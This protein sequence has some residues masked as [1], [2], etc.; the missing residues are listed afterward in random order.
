MLA[1]VANMRPLFHPALFGTDASNEQ[2]RGQPTLCSSHVERIYDAPTD[3]FP[4]TV[5]SVNLFASWRLPPTGLSTLFLAEFCREPG[6][7]LVAAPRPRK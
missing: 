2:S 1:K 5:L 4:Q 3:R 7:T 6:V